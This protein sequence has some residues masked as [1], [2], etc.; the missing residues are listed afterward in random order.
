MERIVAYDVIII[1]AGLAG[2]FCALSLDP[3]LKVALVSKGGVEDTNSYLAQG[4]VAAPV[5]SGDSIQSHIEDTLLCGHGAGDPIA[6]SE[7]IHSAADVIKR[8]ESFGVMFDRNEDGS[9]FLGRE[10][11]HRCA[12]I[13]RVGDFTGR[14]IMEAL[15]KRLKERENVAMMTHT[16]VIN[17]QVRE[18]FKKAVWLRKDV[19]SVLEAGVLVIATGGLGRLYG[20]TSNNSGIT[21]DG[22]AL[23]IRAGLKT[24]ELGLIQFHPTVFQ[25]LNGSQ[26]GFLISEAVRG[27][28]GILRNERNER[29]MPSVHEMAELA[30]RDV[31]SRA[32]QNEISHQSFQH[33]WLDVRHIGSQRMAMHFP[34][35]HAYTAKQGLNLDVDMMPVAPGAHY[36]MGGIVTDI[37]GE[38]SMP[39]VFAVGECACAGVHG[40]NRLASNSLLEAM[41]FA[42]KAAERIASIDASG[43]LQN[44][45]HS[46]VYIDDYSTLQG[47]LAHWMD[48][49]MG[50][51]RNKE[52]ILEM[53]DTLEHMTCEKI[54]LNSAS[55]EVIRHSESMMLLHELLRQTIGEWNVESNG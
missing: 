21:G 37:H 53:L 22:I 13:L 32:I 1:G 30:P 50:V 23:A 28:G 33:V 35:I 39:G 2:V 45:L 46:E 17:I 27:E 49:N 25:N 14:A 48:L 19:Q 54:D 38:T 18:G 10:G 6:V 51:L 41:V 15:W 3:S 40:K 16:E 20:S 5:G 36:L 47:D 42:V 4:G 24:R 52:A 9:Y 7:L 34:T 43:L 12:R 29:F 55:I 8:L 26:E 44:D 11:A 31:V